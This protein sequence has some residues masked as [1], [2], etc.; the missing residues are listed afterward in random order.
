M[1]SVVGAVPPASIDAFRLLS[2]MAVRKTCQAGS[3]LSACVPIV[4][5]GSP[6]P[7]GEGMTAAI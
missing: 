3:A 5:G 1:H 2:V 4:V 6:E 7:G